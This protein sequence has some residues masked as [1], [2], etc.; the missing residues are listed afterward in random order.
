MMGLIAHVSL[1]MNK[2]LPLTPEFIV[3]GL[4]SDVLARFG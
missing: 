1:T 3:T 2:F 4:A